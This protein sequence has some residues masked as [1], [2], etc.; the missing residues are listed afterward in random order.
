MNALE[1][2]VTAN[3]TADN[4]VAEAAKGNVQFY[5]VR[6]NG[7]TRHIPFFA[8]GTKEREEAE[9]IAEQREDGRTMKAIAEELHLSVPSVRRILNSLLLSEEV[10]G[11]EPEDV[12][13]LIIAELPTGEEPVLFTVGTVVN[14]SDEAEEGSP[15]CTKC[16]DELDKGNLCTECAAGIFAS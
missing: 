13:D 1:V 5:K 12:E 3:V 4:F 16:G 7:T 2:R 14:P 6:A 9:W 11:Y 10:E 8:D 15:Q